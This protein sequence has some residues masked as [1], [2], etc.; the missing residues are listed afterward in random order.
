MSGKRNVSLV[1]LILSMF[2]FGTIGVFRK[3]IP[4]PSAYIAVARGA[5]GAL[6]LSIILIF[7]KKS[8]KKLKLSQFI[9]PLISGAFIGLNWILLFEAY[10]YTSVGVATLCY[11]IAPVF[12]ILASPFITG[13]RLTTKKLVCIFIALCGMIP[14]SGILGA[15]KIGVLQIK[16]I[17][18]GLGAALLYASVIL[19]NKK[20]TDIPSFEKTTV[21]LASAAISMMPYILITE[22][23]YLPTANTT[24]LILLLSVGIIHTG[25][26][27]ALYFA[28]M[29]N[30]GAQSV[31]LLSYIDP[32]VAILLSGI[33]LREKMGAAEYLGALLILGST[34]FSELPSSKK[35]K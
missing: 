1:L 25:I 9:L 23:F 30:L 7:R 24:T 3:Y 16:G 19:M 10:N 6:F 28:S 32:V 29:E 22:G 27:Y 5:I 31:A 14:I 8:E 13:E 12:V 35:Q 2:I 18:F 17:L 34:L 21:Q 33:L 20:M 26:A 11:Y 15:E 4:L